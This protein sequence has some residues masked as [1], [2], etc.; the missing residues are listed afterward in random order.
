ME[1][2]GL[3]EPVKK[4]KVLNFYFPDVGALPPPVIA[5]NDITFGYSPEQILYKN[6]NCGVDLESR[7]ALVG[8]NGTGKV[9]H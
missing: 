6:V 3:T 1:R 7:I 2:E 5:F 8:P 4:D 9:P